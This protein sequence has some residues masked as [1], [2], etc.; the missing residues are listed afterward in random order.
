MASARPA[1]SLSRLSR[2]YNINHLYLLSDHCALH[3]D[4]YQPQKQEVTT[5][6]YYFKYALSLISQQLRTVS[7]IKKIKSTS[8]KKS[9]HT[10]ISISKV[11]IFIIIVGIIVVVLVLVKRSIG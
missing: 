2:E 9:L 1:L 4:K 11:F 10:G 3:C 5:T 6:T 8:L 7:W